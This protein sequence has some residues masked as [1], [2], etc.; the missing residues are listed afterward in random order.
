MLAES[1][2]KYTS[3]VHSELEQRLLAHIHA[4]QTAQHYG[5]LLTLMYGYYAAL[6]K[7]LERF[8]E[9]LPDYRDRRKSDYILQD[10]NTLQYS[11][12]GLPVCR[13]IPTISSLPAAL[14]AM[15]VLE[16]STLGGKVISKLLKK[17]LPSLEGSTNFFEGYGEKTGD[18]WQKFRAHLVATVQEQNFNE[19]QRAAHETFSKFKNWIEKNEPAKL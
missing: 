9:V 19:T 14:G 18:M 12:E 8:S 2:K 5:W 15:Y 6:E 10:L 3:E 1:L 7:D 11:T 17:R 16:G 13:D 4:V